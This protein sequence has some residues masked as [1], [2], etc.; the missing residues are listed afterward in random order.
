MIIFR[1]FL[2][3]CDDYNPNAEFVIYNK[4]TRVMLGTAEGL[5][6]Q[7]A[8]QLPSASNVVC[9]LMMSPS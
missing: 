5:I 9:D 8:K 4:K 3:L 2:D 6:K 1:E 7:R